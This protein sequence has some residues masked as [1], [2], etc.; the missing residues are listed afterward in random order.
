MRIL[1]IGPIPPDVGGK[2]S[3]GVASHVWD[4]SNN[5]VKRGHE[6]AILADNYPDAHHVPVKKDGVIIYS[7]SSLRVLKNL[8]WL[9]QN[10]YI[11]FKLIKHFEGLINITQIIKSTIYYKYV[12]EHFKPDIIHVHHLESRFPFAYFAAG[13]EIP[14]ISTIHSLSSVRFT[15]P[16]LSG[17]YSKLMVNNLGL[18]KN[19]VF[20]SHSLRVQFDKLF[21]NFQAKSWII[22]NPVDSEKFYPMDKQRA[23]LKLDLPDNYPI[24]LFVGHLLESKGIYDLIEAVK[25][26]S[27]KSKEFRILFVG[28]GRERR[29]LENKIRSYDLDAVVRLEGEKKYPDLLFYYNAADLFV[30]PSLSESF[31]LVYIESLSCGTPV[32]GCSGIADEAIRDKAIGLLVPPGNPFALAAAIEEGLAKKWEKEIITHYAYEFSWRKRIIEFEKIYKGLN[33]RGQSEI[34]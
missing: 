6:V 13:N 25:I 31:G 15:P 26:L 12:T 22:N 16:P 4:L 7:F 32:I 28:D 11:I 1:Q 27:V 5:L 10:S 3:G 14:I 2:T 34:S 29:G 23:R 24:L 21:G 17:K 9:F 20:V 30:M 33:D 19:L 8:V 18:S